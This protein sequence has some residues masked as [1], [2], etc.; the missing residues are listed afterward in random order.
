MRLGADRSLLIKAFGLSKRRGKSITPKFLSQL[1]HCKD[2]A[3]RELLLHGCNP[4]SAN[5]PT[6]YPA[7]PP[8]ERLDACK[9]EEAREILRAAYLRSRPPRILPKRGPKKNLQPS[10]ANSPARI[11]PPTDCRPSKK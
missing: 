11:S 10:A 6:P 3:A 2:N 7:A 4:G 9:D 8:Q 1:L 5:K